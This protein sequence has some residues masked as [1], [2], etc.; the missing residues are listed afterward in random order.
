MAVVQISR[1]LHRRGLRV[2]LP[3]PLNGAEFGW[4][5]DTRELYIGNGPDFPGNTQILTEVSP[6]SLPQYTY[7]SNTGFDALTGFADSP[8]DPSEPSSSNPVI[9]SYQ[10]KFDDIV[11]VRDYGAIGDFAT[12]DTAALIRGMRDLYD[13]ASGADPRKNRAL[14]L[15]AGIY[16][17]SEAFPFYPFCNVIGDGKGRTIIFLDFS[18]STPDLTFGTG[19]DCVARTVDSLGNS[20]FN[21]GNSSPTF[22][23]QNIK[24][25]GI[26]FESNT[27]QSEVSFNYST[28]SSI[29]EIIKLDQVSD[30]RFDDCEFVGTYSLGDGL[31]TP[32]ILVNGSV[33]VLISRVQDIAIDMKKYTFDSC[34]FRNLVHGFAVFDTVSDVYIV[35]G[36]FKEMHQPVQ[37]GLHPT[38]NFGSTSTGLGGPPGIPELVRVSYSR[39]VDYE[40]V[41][42]DV[43][44]VGR[45]NISSYSHYSATGTTPAVRFADVTTGCVSIGD[46]FDETGSFDCGDKLINLRVQNHSVSNLNVVMNAQDLFQIPFG[47]CGNILIDGDLTVTG[48]ILLGGSIVTTSTPVVA[49]GAITIIATIP[50]TSGNII[51][52]EYGMNLTDTIYRSGTMKI[53]HDGD[54]T[55]AVPTIITFDDTFTEVGGPPAESITLSATIGA[56]DVEIL[57]DPGALS[58]SFN[59]TFRVLTV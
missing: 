8:A 23:P 17:I 44:S 36:E 29:K 38:L 49:P 48:D 12:D 2:D 43:R 40:N 13:D 32:D 58:P 14:Y 34:T 41:A 3:N 26:T 10:Q 37:V 22:L 21:I 4:A 19:N 51:H 50:F 5:Q 7:I 42:F 24:V 33:G 59:S 45:G 46:T 25:S 39:F 35:D 20:A 9:R 1:I 31:A 57:A 52:F 6:A 30:V 11:S 15:P 47:F 56:T 28:N 54:G 53:A 16:R 18:L 27:P 55:A